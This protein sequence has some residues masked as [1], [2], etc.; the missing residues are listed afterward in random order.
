MLSP[1]RRFFEHHDIVTLEKAVAAPP[2]SPEGLDLVEHPQY[3]PHVLDVYRGFARTF[4]DEAFLRRR[5]ASGQLFYELREG[6]LI[7]ATTF[8]IPRGER[9]VDE[10]GLG[11]PVAEGAPW[12]RDIFVAPEARG[13]GRF[14]ML[15]DA[16]LSRLGPKTRVLCSAVEQG[17]GTSLRAHLRYGFAP[18]QRFEVFH[19]GGA[20]LIRRRW[21]P[22]PQRG[23][24]YRPQA[25]ALLTGDTYAR[26]LGA[27]RA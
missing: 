7:R 22:P 15:L 26:F 17:N 12:L 8:L 23:S 19:L 5:F 25:R 18:V 10:I 13:A 24:A 21:P 14:G 1:V 4:F 6:D 16:L 3:S 2:R 20:V 27:H 11:F 9:F